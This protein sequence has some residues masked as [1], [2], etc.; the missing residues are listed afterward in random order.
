[1][2]IFGELRASIQDLLDGRTAPADRTDRIR[3]MKQGLVH[4]RLAID[5][6]R[7]GVNQTRERIEQERRELATVRRRRDAAA[8]ISDTETVEIADRF[9]AHHGERVTVLEAKLAAQ[10]AEAAL[11]E[12]EL[13]EMTTQLRAAASGIGDGPAPRFPS[14]DELGLPDDAPLR[15]ELDG[16]QRA[17]ERETRERD[18]DARLAELKKKMGR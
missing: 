5:D 2:S 14:D 12:R 13:S 17:A 18:A 10:E 16:L 6:L 11:A 9:T 8:A 7:A 3:R 1:L 4:A 15:Q